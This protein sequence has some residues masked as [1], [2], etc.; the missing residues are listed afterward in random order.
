MQKLLKIV[1]GPMKG[2]EVALVAGTRV[3]VG[4]GDGCDI[5]VADSSLPE[6][7][8]ELD[9]SEGSVS[10]ILPDGTSSEPADF[11]IRDFGSTSVAIGPAD[12]AWG[13]LWRKAPESVPASEPEPAKPE[14]AEKPAEP[15]SKPAAETEQKP[16]E[17]GEGK[18]RKG[19][20]CVLVALFVV[21]ALAALAFFVWLHRA[22]ICDR[23]SE[24]RAS[25]ASADAVA[26][27][28]A[29]SGVTLEGIAAEHGLRLEERDGAKWLVGNL[30]RR[31]ER[32]AIR[33]MALAADRSVRLDLT[34]DQ[35]LLA[36]AQETVFNATAGRLRVESVTNRVATV[37]GEIAGPNELERA[38]KALGADVPRLVS[39]V[40][41]GVRWTAA[42]FASAKPVETADA[43]PKEGNPLQRE[44]APRAAVAEPSPVVP[45]AGILEVPYPCVVL[46][47]G[48]RC[49]EGAQIGQF[50]LKAIAADE[51]VFVGP[52]GEF[53]WRP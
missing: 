42:P 4:S 39:C 47:D 23:V 28:P 38:V 19:L 31:T 1:E 35:S 40:T 24:L 21:L 20:G 48:S 13:D 45:V 7:A 33:A 41:E 8:F 49:L 44:L 6:V 22:E 32:M 16:A 43:S 30:Q 51:L 12:G 18:S 9:V 36:A 52:S 27:Q 15:E 50:T 17:G 2:A 3:K 11:E 37:V 10:M 25:K 26:A 46:A 5:I 34:D 53:K 29:E 14:E